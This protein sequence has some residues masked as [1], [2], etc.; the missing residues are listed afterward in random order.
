MLCSSEGGG[1]N[2]R[3]F[4]TLKPRSCSLY[5]EVYWITHKGGITFF[6]FQSV[7]VFHLQYGRI[8]MKFGFESLH[9]I[10]LLEFIVSLRADCYPLLYAKAKKTC[11]ITINSVTLQN[12]FIIQSSVII[13]I[14][15]TV[16]GWMLDSSS[17]C[18]RRPLSWAAASRFLRPFVRFLFSPEVSV[19]L[20]YRVVW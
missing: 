19:R 8:L 7:P 11:N 18:C 16:L 12:Q 20:H 2:A 9:S 6:L 17:E 10:F 13:I 15:S 5:T 1:C 14:G 4:A 3:G